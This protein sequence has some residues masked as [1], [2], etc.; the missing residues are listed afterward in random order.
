MTVTTHPNTGVRAGYNDGDDGWGADD[1]AD[2]RL[3]EAFLFAAT[4]HDITNTPPGSPVW[5]DRYLT[6]GSPTGAWSGHADTVAVYEK[7]EAGTTAWKFYTPK[8]GWRVRVLDATYTVLPIDYTWRNGA[9]RADAYVRTF[10]GQSYTDGDVSLSDLYAAG[11]GTMITMDI[12]AAGFVTSNGT[13]TSGG[14]IALIRG[15][16]TTDP[17]LEMSSY[18]PGT[19][20]A[21]AGLN[22]RLNAADGL[23]T[24]MALDSFANAGVVTFRRADGTKASP[25]ATQ[26]GEAAGRVRG[27]FYDGGVF[28]VG[29]EVIFRALEN[30]GTAGFGSAVVVRATDI[31]STSLTDALTIAPAGVDVV[32][33]LTAG[34]AYVVTAPGTAGLI[35]SD[36]THGVHVV[37]GSGLSFSGG[38]TLDAAGGGG[39]V[40]AAGLVFSD[41][42][43]FQAGVL[44]S[45]LRN[46]GTG[47]PTLDLGATI[48]IDT[49][50]TVGG[51]AALDVSDIGGANGLAF[52][53]ANGYLPF[54]QMQPDI[55]LAGLPIDFSG[56]LDAYAAGPPS[57]GQLKVMFGEKRDIPANFAGA[58]VKAYSFPTSAYAFTILVDHSGTITTL[59]TI[60]ISSGGSIT[61]GSSSLFH[62][63][64]GDVLLIRNAATIDPTLADVAMSFPTKRVAN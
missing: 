51:Y 24:G 53:D 54:S 38:N 18:S 32:G 31:G 34:G 7:N 60:S 64:P 43:I 47:T 9:W 3:V 6:G 10:L 58:R 2:W 27:T 14:L 41:G 25:T 15:T 19:L 33:T 26:S 23:A 12:P 56:T 22:W 13:V 55:E 36:G 52:H 11:L 28:F 46:T 5:G 49:S 63:V 20:Q 16:G 57:T 1:N 61:L 29:A 8:E 62:A 39:S 59:G 21:V 44:S 35:M 42:T 30:H 48:A 4:A 17:Y 40:P 50:L 45:N 37:L